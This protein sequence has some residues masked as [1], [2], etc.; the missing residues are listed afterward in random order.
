V[1]VRGSSEPLYVQVKRHVLAAIDAGEFA[2]GDRIPSE[3][4]LVADLGVSR[5]TVRKALTDLVQEGVLR[6]V[7]ARG[8][9]VA[10]RED[11]YELHALRSFSMEARC[12][13]QQPSSRVLEAEIIAAPA[14]LAAR[15]GIDPGAETVS[16]QRVRL[17]DMVPVI[18]QHSWLPHARCPGLLDQPL[19]DD[20]LYTTLG[21]RFGIAL[22]SGETTISARLAEPVERRLLGLTGP[23]AI[24]LI[25]QVTYDRDGTPIEIMESFQNPKRFP[26]RVLHSENSPARP[27]P[28]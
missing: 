6:P 17:L 23:G 12:R 3:R 4:A 11:P 18:V 7:A 28:A 9:F 24:L 15:L 10:G 16:L 22:A 19:I 21:E 8:F 13:G 27:G 20:S 1:I 2:V 14:P 26:L 25:D 5:I